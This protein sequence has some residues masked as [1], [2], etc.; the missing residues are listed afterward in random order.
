MAEGRFSAGFYDGWAGPAGLVGPA[1]GTDGPDQR[2]WP[3]RPAGGNEIFLFGVTCYDF[4]L[5]WSHLISCDL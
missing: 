3:D 5:I 4:L 1:A 2:V